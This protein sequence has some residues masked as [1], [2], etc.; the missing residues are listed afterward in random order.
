[1]PIEEETRWENVLTTCWTPVGQCLLGIGDPFGK[2]P[3][4]IGDLV[5]NDFS[6]EETF[7]EMPK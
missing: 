6:V 5:G 3:N 4:S 7:W 2:F 1:M